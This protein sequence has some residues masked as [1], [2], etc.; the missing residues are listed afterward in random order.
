MIPVEGQLLEGKFDPTLLNATV[1]GAIL[2][3]KLAETFRDSSSVNF[4]KVASRILEELQGLH[5]IR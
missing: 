5:I 1:L 2:R 3:K 4:T